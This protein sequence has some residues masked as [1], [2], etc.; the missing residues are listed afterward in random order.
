MLPLNLLQDMHADRCFFNADDAAG[1]LG[2]G[3]PDALGLA[4]AGLSS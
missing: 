4:L 1:V 3:K 2:Q